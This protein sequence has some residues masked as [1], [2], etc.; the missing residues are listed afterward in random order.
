MVGNMILLCPFDPVIIIRICTSSSVILA[1]WD[2]DDVV[3]MVIVM[4]VIVMMWWEGDSGDVVMVWWWYGAQASMCYPNC[5]YT[6][7]A[8]VLY[9]VALLRGVGLVRRCVCGGGGGVGGG[10]E[11]S[12]LPSMVARCGVCAGLSQGQSVH[13][14]V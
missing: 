6:E 5:F 13:T 3:V 8:Q 12:L 4:M 9:S 11:R 10:S 1:V 14:S 2:G 7:I